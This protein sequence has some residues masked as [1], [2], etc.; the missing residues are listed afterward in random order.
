MTLYYKD[1]QSPLGLLRLIA[2]DFSLKAVLWEAD[3]KTK[4]RTLESVLKE[5]HPILVETERQLSEYFL[6]RIKQFNLPIE[7]VGTEFQKKVWGRLLEIPYGETK[8]YMELAKMI[9]QPK[10]VRAVG[11]A[12][13]KN[14][15]AIIIPC[16][17]VIGA[18]GALTG[19]SGTVSTKQVLL[20]L[21]AK[22]RVG[23]VLGE[24]VPLNC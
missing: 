8:S 23:N 15:L 24:A 2:N 14:P 18:N 4:V 6:G 3:T 5:D 21:E 16:H 17:R 1:I 22:V 11:G 20:S 13:S 19:F 9:E 7:P 12:N 10:A